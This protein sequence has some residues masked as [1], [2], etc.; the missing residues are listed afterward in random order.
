[1]KRIMLCM[2]IKSLHLLPS[3]ITDFT[4]AAAAATA[5]WVGDNLWVVRCGTRVDT[6]RECRI[7]SSLDDRRVRLM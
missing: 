3:I 4:A 7:C 1:M 6:A 2:T 5:R